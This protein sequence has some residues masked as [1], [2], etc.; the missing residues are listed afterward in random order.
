MNQKYRIRKQSTKNTKFVFDSANNRIYEVF[1]ILSHSTQP[2]SIVSVSLSNTHFRPKTWGEML[3]VEL[4]IAL[5]TDFACVHIS[6]SI[7]CMPFICVSVCEHGLLLF[8][9]YLHLFI[10]FRICHACA[11]SLCFEPCS[12]AASNWKFSFGIIIVI[13]LLLLSITTQKLELMSVLVVCS[14]SVCRWI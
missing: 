13:S 3:L 2:V 4:L 5:T 1:I 6:L 14:H 12:T 11:R 10:T 8:Q 9:F 7:V